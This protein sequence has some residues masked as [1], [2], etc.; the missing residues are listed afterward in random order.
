MLEFT[1]I[2]QSPIEVILLSSFSSAVFYLISYMD[3]ASLYCGSEHLIDMAAGQIQLAAPTPFCTLTGLSRLS[4]PE[5]KQSSY[6]I[7]HTRKYIQW[8]FSGYRFG[9]DMC[10]FATCIE[11]S[12]LSLTFMFALSC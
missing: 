7:S 9:V 11:L 3:S 4:P 8:V 5:K 1:L 12:V 10:H 2:S 6:N